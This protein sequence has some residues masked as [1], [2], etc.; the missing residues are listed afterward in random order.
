MSTCI[1]SQGNQGM[2]LDALGPSTLTLE[3]PACL[4]SCPT[5]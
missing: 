3:I 1:S 4:P 5:P 2:G